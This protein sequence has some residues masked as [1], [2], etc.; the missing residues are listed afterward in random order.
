MNNNENAEPH[1]SSHLQ[2]SEQ[3]DIAEPLSYDVNQV[4]TQQQAYNEALVQL[5]VLLY[6]IDGKVTLTEQDYFDATVEKLNW[7][8]GIA[9]TAFINNAIHEARVAIDTQQTRELLFSLGAALSYDP[10]QALEAAMDITEVD[11]NR[12][13]EELE[14]LAL[15]SNRVL[16]RGLVA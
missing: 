8:S 5:L 10:A 7:R 16:A 13:D 14:L 6:Q 3:N 9:L 4:I 15:L 11:G 12:S 1:N 2:N